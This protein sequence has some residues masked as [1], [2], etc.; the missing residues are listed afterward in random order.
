M[1]RLRDSF[2]STISVLR[3]LTRW[4]I[5]P[6]FRQS[7]VERLGLPVERDLLFENISKRHSEDFTQGSR[8]VTVR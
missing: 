7:S 2:S 6:W 1:Y 8:D 3:I 5:A 4:V